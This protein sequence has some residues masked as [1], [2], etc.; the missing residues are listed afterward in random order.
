MAGRNVRDLMGHNTSDL[1]FVV[2]RED[3]AFIYKKESAGQRECVDLI[4]IDYLDREW[5][6]CV[7]MQNNVLANAIN[8]FGYQWIV[9]HFRLLPYFECKLPTDLHFLCL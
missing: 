6:L 9:D 8:V 3:Q 1:G 4:A 2:S 7:R 5:D